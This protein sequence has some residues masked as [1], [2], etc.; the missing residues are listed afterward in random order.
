MSNIKLSNTDIIK[1]ILTLD[2]NKAHGHGKIRFWMVKFCGNSRTSKLIFKDCLANDIFPFHRKN[3]KIL[4]VHKNTM[5]Q[6]LNNYRL[7]SLLPICGKTLEQ[8]FLSKMSSFFTER[9]LIS[10]CQSGFKPRDSC[11]NQ[12]LSTACQIYGSFNEGIVDQTWIRHDCNG[13]RNHNH[14]VRWAQFCF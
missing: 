11:I 3:R 2:P 14:L 10:H 6:C 8:L 9:D 5:K 1:I 12:L 4:P 7:I 13:I